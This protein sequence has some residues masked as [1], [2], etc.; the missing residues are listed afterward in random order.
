MSGWFKVGQAG[1]LFI[2]AAEI[3]RPPG[4]NRLKQ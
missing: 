4:F 3:T 1:I 2:A